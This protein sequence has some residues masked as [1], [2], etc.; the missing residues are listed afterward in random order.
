MFGDCAC[1]GFRV[2]G[3]GSEFEEEEGGLAYGE[4]GESILGD[5]LFVYME[6]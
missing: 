3:C 6:W 2:C 5:G 4:A 1:G